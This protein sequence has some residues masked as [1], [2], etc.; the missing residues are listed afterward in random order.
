M[1]KLGG[2]GKS[3]LPEGNSIWKPKGKV[4]HLTC[5]NWPEV[6]GNGWHEDEAG[7]LVGGSHTWYHGP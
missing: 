5:K 1:T 2:Q 6:K 3:S 4:L 7:R